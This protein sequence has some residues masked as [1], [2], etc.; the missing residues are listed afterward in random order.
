MSMFDQDETLPEDKESRGD[1]ILEIMKVREI[2]LFKRIKDEENKNL[3]YLIIK[4][5][6]IVDISSNLNNLLLSV[7]NFCIIF[8]GFMLYLYLEI[9]PNFVQ[10]GL[11]RGR[12]E[13]I[14]RRVLHFRLVLKNLLLLHPSQLLLVMLQLLL[15]KL[16]PFLQQARHL[17]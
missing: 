17:L 3:E 8:Q 1:Y 15:V 12:R 11:K 2:S 4:G 14:F 10:N 16:D 7:S 5:E 13:V 9:S 6:D